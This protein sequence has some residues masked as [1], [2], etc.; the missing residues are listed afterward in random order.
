[1]KHLL[2]LSILLLI[3]LLAAPVI[4]ATVTCP[5][6][7]T[8]LLPAE[9]K[10][11]GLPGYCNGKQVICATDGK[12][13]KY[14]YART[15]TVTTITTVPQMIVTGFHTVPTTVPEFVKCSPGCSCKYE[16]LGKM[17]NYTLCGGTQHLCGMDRNDIPMYCYVTPQH[18]STGEEVI[19]VDNNVLPVVT[20][21][22]PPL[23]AP[24]TQGSTVSCGSGCTC[25][26]LEDAAK[27]GLKYC[28][29]K[30]ASCSV[31]SG[32]TPTGAPKEM[33]YCFTIPALTAP[34][35][36]VSRVA[37]VDQTTVSPLAVTKECPKG[38]SCLDEK[39]IRDKG[40]FY[41]STDRTECGLE[42]SGEPLYCAKTESGPYNVKPSSNFIS[43]IVGFFGALFGIRSSTGTA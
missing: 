16:P 12:I 40:Y 5:S 1:M 23:T 43:D 41:C 21:V 29:G 33:R 17:A 32:L 13:D 34:I 38:C 15:V 10:N 22:P 7:C 42:A 27:K 14:C 39:T 36:N 30:Q 8:C 2:Y 31:S 25:L 18:P 11:L 20:K 19:T 28:G 4:A 24:F 26:L 3:S 35:T 6:D 9:A 37:V